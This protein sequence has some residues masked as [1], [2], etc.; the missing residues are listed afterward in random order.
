M[1]KDVIYIEP[2][3]D[4]TDIISRIKSSKQKVVA[5]VPPKKLG[6]MR[7]AVN[8][9]LIARTSKSLE[10]VAVIITTD[11]SLVKLSA[12]SGLP[13]AKSLSSRPM[14]PSEFTKRKKQ[15][16]EELEEAELDK[17]AEDDSN[18]EEVIDEKK[19]SKKGDMALDSDEVENNE[20]DDDSKKDKKKK[21]KDK[22]V[23][24]IPNFDKYRKWIIF[25]GAGVVLFTAVI[26]WAF[27]IAPAASIK[28]VMKTVSS[29][30]SENVTL[31]TDEKSKDNKAGKF[32]LEQ[33]KYEEEKSIEFEATGKANKGEKATGTVTVKAAFSR[34]TNGGSVT[35]PA[36]STVVI[37]GKNYTTLEATTASWE[38][39]S[40][41]GCDNRDA[42][43]CYILKKVAVHAAGPGTAYNIEEAHSGTINVNGV[44]FY[45]STA[46]TG[47]TDKNVTVVDEKDIEDAKKQI[48]SNDNESK[49]KLFEQIKDGFVKIESSYKVD[50]KDPVSA[51]KK[52][53]EVADKKKAKLTVKAVYTIYVVDRTAIDEYVKEFEKD[54]IAENDKIYS[55]GTPFFER[56]LEG[57]DGIYTAKFKTTVKIGPELSETLVLDTAKGKK[58]GEVKALIKDISPNINDVNVT[59][60]FPWVYWVPDDANRIKI[61]IT[62]EE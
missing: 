12:L 46:M 52:G 31:V 2:E 13:V 39:P 17:P 38:G 19:P 6:I 57:K 27:I 21:K 4:I 10:K 9:K 56:F 29:N 28:V 35:V 8:T 40:T 61:D 30:I 7:S 1:N 23:E 59:P 5:L 22:D 41:S 32:L 3:D 62:V 43:Y 45:A 24:I 51:P 18:A 14:L 44:S 26:I 58:V 55:T 42:D 15:E 49:D 37:S 53:E 47:G 25:G 11:P 48:A 20:E 16:T 50:V 54:K 36:G 60:S 34:E 33:I